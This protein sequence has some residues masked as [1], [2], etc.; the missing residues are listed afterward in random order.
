MSGDGRLR[1]AGQRRRLAGMV[2]ADF[3]HG[4][5][6]RSAQAQ[7]HERQ[8]N[9]VVEVADRREHRIGSELDTQDRCDHLLNCRLAVAADN[10][11][12]RQ[13]E[14]PA[15]ERG[16]P[17]QGRQRIGD[18][19][20]AAVPGKRSGAVSGD[21]RRDGA[22]LERLGHEIVAV[23]ALALERD[24]EITGLERARIGADAIEGNAGSGK[25]AADCA[26]GNCGVHHRPLRTARARVA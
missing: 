15:P 8:A 3:E 6:M 1:D 19:E 13:H 20:Q 12:D 26:S 17:S 23:E 9:L 4:D 25:R 7:H 21:D 24:E 5:A 2:H 16:E 10:H 18:R 22:A 11:D 14:T